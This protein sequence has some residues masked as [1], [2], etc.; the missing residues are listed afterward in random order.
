MDPVTGRVKPHRPLGKASPALRGLSIGTKSI[1]RVNSFGLLRGYR[2]WPDPTVLERERI[3]VFEESGLALSPS[4]KLHVR[5]GYPYPLGTSRRGS[6]ANFAL[7]A[8]VPNVRLC[9]FPPVPLVGEQ[10]GHGGI[11]TDMVEEIVLDPDMNR[12]GNVWHILVEDLPP[13]ALYG[14]RIGDVPRIILDPYAK[15]VLSGA[16]DMWMRYEGE[17]REI[18]VESEHRSTS[19]NCY[20]DT[21]KKTLTDIKF[22]FRLAR[23]CT[24]HEEEFDWQDDHKRRPRI[25]LEDLI[26]YEAHVRGLTMQMPQ[27]SAAARGTFLGVVEAIP[28]LKELGINAVELMPVFH[29]EELELCP[30]NELEL[31]FSPTTGEQLV[32]FWG[33]S[34]VSFFAPMTKYASDKRHVS[35]E[36]KMMVRALHAADIEVILDVVYNHTADASAPFHF[37]NDAKTWYM[38]DD[39]GPYSNLSGCGNTLNANHP[40]VIELVVASLRWWVSEY[41]VDGFRFDAAGILCRDDDG[42]VLERPPIIEAISTDPL[43]SSVKLI[44]EAWDAGAMLGSPNYL[45]GEFGGKRHEHRWMEWNGKWRDAVRRFIRGSPAMVRDFARS[46]SGF[47]DLY[48]GRRHGPCHGVNFVA[49]HDGFTLADLVSYDEKHNEA[50]EGGN[51]DGIE[52]NDSWNC[53]HEGALSTGPDGVVEERHRPVQQLRRRQIRNFILALLVSRGVPM[54]H[55]GDEVGH[56]K[57]GNNNSFCFDGPINYL[58]WGEQARVDHDHLWRFVKLAIAWRRSMRLLRRKHFMSWRDAV[59]HGVKPEHPDWSD[60]SRFIALSLKNPRTG[61]SLIY[62]AFNASTSAERVR[63]PPPPTDHVW[64]RIADTNL[65]SPRDFC[66]VDEADILAADEYWVADHSTLILQAANLN[67][68]SEAPHAAEANGS[69]HLSSDMPRASSYVS[70][71]ELEDE[72]YEPWGTEEATQ[73]AHEEATQD[74]QS[75]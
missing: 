71:S 47:F 23:V 41:H 21:P 61:S 26:I 28:Y 53:G 39:Q 9:L 66:T 46:L 12:T 44:A 57:H 22:P 64:I 37:L 19:V 10:A 55:M 65:S 14:Y 4:R 3:R 54:L 25:P 58:P 31:K 33:Y 45:I 70:A 6:A 17:M 50:N 18:P 75:N 68:N 20:F 30:F 36:F 34:P 35:R 56:T 11:V 38:H 29:F 24:E 52:D 49:C 63:L 67:A 7:F 1:E 13:G 16:V 8:N 42:Q 74:R 72:A 62:V 32:N 51:A 27:A 40:V 5:P 59:W 43:L 60:Q 73:V 48:A 69:L 15:Y 2:L